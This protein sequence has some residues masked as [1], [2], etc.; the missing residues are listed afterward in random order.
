MKIYLIEKDFRKFKY[1]KAYF[2]NENVNLINDK[3]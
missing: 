1:L 2:G 3:F